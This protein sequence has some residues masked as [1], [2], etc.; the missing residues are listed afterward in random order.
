MPNRMGNFVAALVIAP[1]AGIALFVSTDRAAADNCLAAPKGAAPQGSH[2]YYR[3]DRAA[4]RNCW[5]VRAQTATPNASRNSSIARAPAPEAPL[6]PALAN[7]RAEAGPADVG[8]PEAAT[9]SSTTSTTD[10]STGSSTDSGQSA[11][12][13]RW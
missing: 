4:K 13:S 11:L 7:A 8:Q 5:Y 12:A 9:R 2:W 3:L 10:S 1:L 6:Q